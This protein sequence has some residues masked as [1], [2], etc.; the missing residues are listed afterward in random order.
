[1]QRR[2]FIISLSSAVAQFAL[3]AKL[4]SVSGWS[5]FAQKGLLMTYGPNVRELY[6]STRTESCKPADLPVEV[7]TKFYLAINQ[8]TAKGLSLEIPPA[9]LTRADEG[10]E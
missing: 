5:P 9:L 1:M 10:I 3:E 8:R 7:P 6:R 2:E 4:P